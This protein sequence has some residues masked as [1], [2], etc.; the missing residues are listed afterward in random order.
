MQS[1]MYQTPV[2]PVFDLKLLNRSQEAHSSWL[3]SLDVEQLICC[4]GLSSMVPTV[5]SQV[6]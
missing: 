4:L 6:H 1:M 3:L 5:C 2:Y